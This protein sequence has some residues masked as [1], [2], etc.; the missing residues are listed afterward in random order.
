MRNRLVRILCGVLLSM[1]CLTAQGQ[2]DTLFEPELF[3]IED[4]SKEGLD[5]EYKVSGATRFLQD[6]DELAVRT[7]VVTRDEIQRNGYITLVDVL[8]T[9]PGFRTSQ[10]GS[11]MMGETFLMRG[12]IGNLYTKILINGMPIQPSGTRGMPLGANLPVQNAERIEIILGAASSV[13]G[14]DAM[15]GVINIVTGDVERPVEA[16]GGVAIGTRS[17]DFLQLSLGGKLGRGDNILDY[18]FYASAYDI[19]D[20]AILFEGSYDSLNVGRLEDLPFGLWVTEEGD[21]LSPEI[22]RIPHSSRLIGLNVGFRGLS[23]NLN[24]MHRSDHSGVGSHFEDIGFYNPNT[25][26][27]EDIT[28]HTLQ[29]GKSFG[30]FDLKASGT[31]NLYEM[32]ENSTYFGVNHPLSSYRNNMYAESQDYSLEAFLGYKPKPYLDILVGGNY[33]RQEGIA[34]QGYLR[35]PWDDERSPRPGPN[36]EEEVINASDSISTIESLSD[37]NRYRSDNIG[38]MGQVYFHRGNWRITANARFDKIFI[39][40]PRF[41]PG[42]GINYKVND[43]FRL[44]GLATQAF[45]APNFFYIYNNY[46][47]DTVDL[48][49]QGGGPGGGGGGGGPGPGSPPEVV[50][51]RRTEPLL[52]ESMVSWEVGFDWQLSKQFLLSGHIFTHGRR[53]NIFPEINLPSTAGPGEIDPDDFEVRYFNATSFSRLTGLQVFLNYN[54]QKG[55]RVEG[56]AQANLGFER[57]DSVVDLDTSYSNVSRFMAGVNV[58]AKLPAKFYLSVFSKVFSSYPWAV[59]K[60]DREVQ[61]KESDGFY[62]IDVVLGNNLTKRLGI[63]IRLTNATR[64]VNHGLYTNTL[65]GYQFDY[66]PQPGRHIMGGLTFDLNR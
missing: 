16:R 26:F 42:L 47:G 49:M 32:D 28:V 23:Y 38:F 51:E 57:I 15:A 5:D 55:L 13:Y 64:S 41:T 40:D 50:L 53:N 48:P 52:A 4:L 17:T 2:Q 18:N 45:R 22:Q 37:L 54:D 19:Y 3:S 12:L 14:S 66:I 35:D 20:Q 39:F 43:N 34:Y 31:I 46:R 29:Y 10:P 63:Y 30:K 56:F 6:A 59:Q 33:T 60:V 27:A 8:K 25:Y 1:G 21:S 61:A 65:S 58:H 24:L 36:D 11:A 62:N 9:L 7:I 44:R